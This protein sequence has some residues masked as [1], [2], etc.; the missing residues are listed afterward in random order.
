MKQIIIILI[1]FILIGCDEEKVQSLIEQ[2]S[3]EVTL[4]GDYSQGE[5]PTYF[6]CESV[7]CPLPSFDVIIYT[8]KVLNDDITVDITY[9]LQNNEFSSQLGNKLLSVP[10]IVDGN[11]DSLSHSFNGILDI[12]YEDGVVDI[13]SGGRPVNRSTLQFL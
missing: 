13:T 1:G 11:I 7:E 3:G 9:F 8:V 2:K 4:V 12:T 5:I 10:G 6:T